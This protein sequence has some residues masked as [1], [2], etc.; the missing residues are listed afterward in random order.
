LAGTEFK[1]S[2][3]QNAAQ[4]AS[5]ALSKFDTMV[6]EFEGARLQDEARIGTM[7]AG[8][9]PEAEAEITQYVNTLRRRLAQFGEFIPT[10]N[11]LAAWGYPELSNHVSAWLNFIDQRAVGYTQWGVEVHKMI[12]NDQVLK[13]RQAAIDEWRASQ[14]ARNREF[15]G[16]D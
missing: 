2:I 16:R 15:Q 8:R 5:D 11:Q 6:S 3:P 4:T 7:V 10:A 14:E 1:V 9:S 13:Q 12:V